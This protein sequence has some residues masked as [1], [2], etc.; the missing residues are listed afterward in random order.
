MIKSAKRAINAILGNAD[1]TDEERMTAIIGSEGLINSRPLTYQTANPSGDVPLT[2]NHFVHGQVGGK[3]APTL[4]DETDFN[5][6]SRWRR[7]QELVRHFWHRWLRER[8]PELIARKKWFRPGGDLRVGDVVIVMSPD[9][10]RGNWPL[11]MV[12]ET[13]PGTDGRVHVVKIQVGQTTMTRAVT[14]LC[15]LEIENYI[16]FN[17][18]ILIIPK[19]N[20]NIL[21]ATEIVCIWHTY[22]YLIYHMTSNHFR[23]CTF[24]Q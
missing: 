18:L 1:V 21:Y 20:L 19:R 15:P 6:R 24:I 14:K 4:V 11:G 2:P 16:L 10:T 13:Y 3:F 17:V 22:I 7:I 23:C 5:P 12:F 9:T 8:L